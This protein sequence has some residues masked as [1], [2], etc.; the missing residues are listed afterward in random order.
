MGIL[1]RALLPVLVLVASACKGDGPAEPVVP[2]GPSGILRFNY[3]GDWNG[4][5]EASGSTL[6]PDG[7]SKSIAE[8]EKFAVA[9]WSST[10]ATLGI[11]AAQ[12]NPRPSDRFTQLSI[13]LDRVTAPG[14]YRFCRGSAE[15]SCAEGKVY[16]DSR[17]WASPTVLYGLEGGTLV[18]TEVTRDRV[19]GTFE[20]P[21]VNLLSPAGGTIHVSGGSFDLAVASPEG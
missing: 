5:F 6:R 18:I 4:M 17:L 2:E 13:Q 19:R 7:T 14:T 3:S 16:F 11:L 10:R 9:G 12:R 8:T 20:A 1:S 21:G 15:G